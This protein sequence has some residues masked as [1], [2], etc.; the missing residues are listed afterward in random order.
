MVHEPAAT[1]KTCSACGLSKPASEFYRHRAQCK[2][3][4][5]DIVEARRQARARERDELRERWPNVAEFD[6]SDVRERSE[7]DQNV[8]AEMAVRAA[9]DG[10]AAFGTPIE[11]ACCE[12]VLRLG[13]IVAAAEELQLE[14]HQLRAHLSELRRRAAAR[15]FS[16]ASD[17]TKTTPEGFHVKGV[18]TYYKIDPDTGESKPAGQWVKTKKDEDHQYAALIA[19]MAGVAAAWTGLADPAPLV[20]PALDD[21]LL[22]VYPMGD[23]HLGMY[24]WAAETGAHFDLD[25]AERNLVA[26][27]DHLVGLAPPAKRALIINLGDFFHSDTA[28]GTTTAGTRVDTDTRWAKVLRIGIRAMRRCIDRALEKHE[29]VHVICEIGNHDSHAAVMLALCLA[30]YYEREPRVFIDTSPAKFHW[31]RFGKNLIGTTHSDTCKPKDLL[32]VM[33]C[34]RPTDVGETLHRYFYTGHVHHDSVKEFPGLIVESFRTLAPKD[35]W[36]AAQGYRS[37]QDMKL[38]ILHKDHGRINRHIVG[39]HQLFTSK[40]AV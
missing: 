23:P 25:I 17:M 26:A 39:I 32:G 5:N 14:P 10:L 18:S 29:L 9:G 33:V 36:H 16:P 30:Q 37:G 13:S 2:S 27:V 6:L 22:A 34:D 8:E 7:E 35:A 12:A 11:G 21:D 19:A 40:G 28:F 1:E 31:Y 4:Y 24:A 15:G 3:C 20:T 38:D